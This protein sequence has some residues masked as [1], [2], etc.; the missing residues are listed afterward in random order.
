MGVVFWDFDGTLAWREGMWRSALIQA[1]DEVCAGHRVTP[2]AIRPG[3]VDGFLW[4]R[5]DQPHHH[6]NIPERW[7]QALGPL[8]VR[9]YE[10]AGVD[11][12]TALAAAAQVPRVYVDPRHWAVFDDTKPT[13]TRLREA[14]WRHIIVS[15]HV[16][17]LP[18]LVQD[19]GLAEFIDEVLTSATTGYEKPHP[20]VFAI[21]LARAGS[22]TKTW[23]VGDSPTAD[24][25]GAEQAGI[26]ALLVRKPAN[27][28]TPNPDLIWAAGVILD[29]NAAARR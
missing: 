19:L 9:A 22:P 20:Q 21:A 10:Q 29:S 17:E 7:W 12:H 16:P 5:A 1:L 25:D 2:E 13:L 28:A 11:H 26:P 14:G 24:I 23:M 6:L 4:H 15:N 3:L 27:D 18:Q 8:F